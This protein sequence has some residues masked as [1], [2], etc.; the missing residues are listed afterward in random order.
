MDPLRFQPQR[1]K[2]KR[3]MVDMVCL[4]SLLPALINPAHEDYFFASDGS[5]WMGLYGPSSLSTTTT[6]FVSLK[7]KRQMVDMVCLDSLLPALINPAH[8]DYFFA[9][10]ESC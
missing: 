5:C 1:L 8:E 4:D 2:P 9:S 6:A 10:D 7:P 3:Q